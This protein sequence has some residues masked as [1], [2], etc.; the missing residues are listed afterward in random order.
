LNSYKAL[1]RQVFSSGE[2][3]LVPIRLED[4]LDI[5][6]WRNE[7]MYHLRQSAPLT[8]DDQN[9]YFDNVVSALF[10]QEKP[11][12]LLFSFL[13]NDQCIGYGGL[14][15]INWID[16]NAEISFIMD[17]SLEKEYFEE[18]WFKYLSLIEKLSFQELKLH[19]IF[20]Y[21]FDLRP[22]LYV[23]LENAGFT[24]EVTL[25]EHCLF[26]YKFIDVVI[27][28]LI[29]DEFNFKKATMNDAETTFKWVNNP[30]IRSFSFNQN[31]ITFENHLQWFGNKLKDST[32]EYFIA[33]DRNMKIGSIRFDITDN[34]A[35]LSYLIDPECQGKGYGSKILKAGIKKLKNIRKEVELISGYVM[36]D[37]KAS[38]HI[39]NKLNFDVETVEDN[40]YFFLKTK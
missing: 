30:I 35:L 2:Y 29:A 26:D 33:Y 22:R 28:T 32:C 7:Q 20:T 31:Q 8:V 1:K 17:S 24:K 23:A 4:R 5:M 40:L 36:P 34:N 37:N 13:K 6:K 16:K 25:K 12:Q 27:H 10:D 38:I 11:D 15:H 9:Y 21:A 18:L 39:F 19:K 3:R 14:V